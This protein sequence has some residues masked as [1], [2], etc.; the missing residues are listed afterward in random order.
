VSQTAEPLL[1]ELTQS[2]LDGETLVSLVQDL[3]S[4]TQILEVLTKG[5]L[6]ARADK[7]E[8]TLEE[9]VTAL[10]AG[11]VRGVQIR[12]VWE[13]TQWLDTLINNQGTIRIVR[14]RGSADSCSA[15][16]LTSE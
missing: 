10:C 2:E 14:T 9:A 13:G 15:P 16:P 12:Y 5:G 1:P 7:T 4:Q 11:A 3:T 8:L 6:C